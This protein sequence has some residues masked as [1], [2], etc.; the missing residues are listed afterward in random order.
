MK[1][2]NYFDKQQPTVSWSEHRN[3]KCR[4]HKT[5]RKKHKKKIAEKTHMFKQK[6]KAEKNT[7]V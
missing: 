7:D 6:K 2:K 4:N 5:Q 1:G 3:L